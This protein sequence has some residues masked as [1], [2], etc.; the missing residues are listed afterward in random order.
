MRRTNSVILFVFSPQRF[1]RAKSIPYNPLWIKHPYRNIETNWPLY[2]YSWL[3]IC[4]IAR[5]ISI[6]KWLNSTCAIFGV[7]AYA[8]SLLASHQ[9]VN[10]LHNKH[11]H[12]DTLVYLMLLFYEVYTYALTRWI[13][14]CIEN[15]FTHM[16]DNYIW[17][18]ATMKTMI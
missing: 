2:P 12:E 10:Y 15:V 9:L 17:E 16:T 13:L 11:F 4:K 1:G 14:N 7:Y 5:I 18:G 3:C 6:G 8:S